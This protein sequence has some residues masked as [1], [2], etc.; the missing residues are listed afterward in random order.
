MM[1]SWTRS[2]ITEESQPLI[3]QRT[4]EIWELVR[5]NKDSLDSERICKLI[6]DKIRESMS[7]YESVLERIISEGDYVRRTNKELRRKLNS[8]RKEMA[9]ALKGPK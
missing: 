9:G 8:V 4:W 6:A 3:E 1:S 5:D 2:H 7:N